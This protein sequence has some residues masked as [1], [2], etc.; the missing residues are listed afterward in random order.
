MSI[1]SIEKVRNHYVAEVTPYEGIRIDPEIKE[2]LQKELVDSFEEYYNLN[3]RLSPENYVDL[4]SVTSMEK[5]SNLI[6]SYIIL[7]VQEKQQLL[8]T[9]N[10][11]ERFF[12]LIEFLK[13][14]IGVLRLQKKIDSEVREKFDKT[15]REYYLREQLRV[16]Q[17]ELGEGDGEFSDDIEKYR[18][19]MHDKK[20]PENVTKKLNEEI[21]RL[22]KMPPMMAES[23]V[24]RN[25]IEWVLALP[26]NKATEDE[27]D[28][29][30]A[31]TMLDEDHYGLDDVK[32]RILEYLAVC[33][34]SDKIKAPILCLVGPPGVGKTS[35]GRSVARAMSRNI[36]R[37]SLGGIRD[38]AEIRGHRRTYV[39][40]MP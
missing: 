30:K 5:L 17:K 7:P 27:L 15:Q 10:G 13:R 8:T 29:K 20:L 31:K 23:G 4:S 35:L 1:D 12:K 22:A 9:F 11:E 34:L 25:Y 39:G 28:I 33:K 36:V 16:I 6:S 32:E 2:A 19:K 37:I 26:W 3:K 40:A 14:E 21:T 24:V 18:Q 38:E